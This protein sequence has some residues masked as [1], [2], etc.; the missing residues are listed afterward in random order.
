MLKWGGGGN[1]CKVVRAFTLVELLVVIAIIG[2]LI[3]LLLPAVQAAREA[4]RRMQ[5]AN[6]QRQWLLALHNYH[7][8]HQCFPPHGI[9]EASDGGPGTLPRAMPFIEQAALVQNYDFSQNVFSGGSGYNSYYDELRAVRLNILTC[10]S[11]SNFKTARASEGGSYCVCRGS[12]IDDASIVDS[13][14]NPSTADGLFRMGYGIA[15][16]HIHDGT[17]NTLALSEGLYPLDR[18]IPIPTGSL[19]SKYPIYS[20]GFAGFASEAPTSPGGIALEANMDVKGWSAEA[21]QLGHADH[22]LLWLPSRTAYLTFDT[23]STPNNIAVGDIWQ[24]NTTNQF[25]VARSYHTGGVVTVRADAST[26]FESN[27]IDPKVWANLGTTDK[28]V[29]PPH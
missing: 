26:H 19:S 28:D 14:A 18:N 10:P 2:M 24:R 3:A 12:A 6:N 22:C 27:S 13:S 29:T 15:L 7:D 16:G 17:S 21:T 5:C 4:A 25:I 1:Q 23:Y 11:D 8:V 20:R 9:R